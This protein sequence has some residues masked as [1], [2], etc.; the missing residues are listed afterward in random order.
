MPD[1]CCSSRKRP[2]TDTSLHVSPNLY[3]VNKITHEPLLRQRYA[4]HSRY[5]GSDTQPP[6]ANVDHLVIITKIRTR[7][8]TNLEV[9][10]KLNLQ[11][12]QTRRGC[13]RVLFLY[14]SCLPESHPP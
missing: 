5:V 2:L 8:I 6:T 11:S 4:L 12:Y 14:L 7:G 3:R 13:C 1:E 9:V 10:F